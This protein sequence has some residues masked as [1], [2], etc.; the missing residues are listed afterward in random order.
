MKSIL[1]LL[2]VIIFY[3][4]VF[5]QNIS[6][7]T[8]GASN[9]VASS[10][11]LTASADSLENIFSNPLSVYFRYWYTFTVV[12]DADIYLSYAVDFPASKT[13]LLKANESYSSVYRDVSLF[14]DYYLKSVSGTANVRLILEGR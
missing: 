9:S 2:P 11:T 10:V 4:Q 5:A 3:S 1:F 7:Y 8:I 13:F 12:T 6:S 14:N